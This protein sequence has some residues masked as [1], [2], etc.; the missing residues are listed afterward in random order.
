MYLQEREFN[1]QKYMSKEEPDQGYRKTL[2]QTIED[3]VTSPPFQK[4][5]MSYKLDQKKQEV[6]SGKP[7]RFYSLERKDATEFENRLAFQNEVET[8]EKEDP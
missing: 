6:K 3:E 8:K 2:N 1:H 5:Q 4:H 7:L